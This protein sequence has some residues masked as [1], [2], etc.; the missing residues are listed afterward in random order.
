[1]TMAYFGGIEGGATNTVATIIDAAGKVLGKGRRGGCN[2][3]QIG[4]EPAVDEIV[5]AIEDAKAEAGLK[6]GVTLEGLGLCL[7]GC[8]QAMID[9]I[10]KKYPGLANE[11]VVRDDTIG[12]IATAF[13]RG[14]IVLIAGTGSNCVYVGPDGA[15]K[16]CG[17]WGHFMGDEGSAWWIAHRAIKYLIDND[18]NFKKAPFDV[19]T[20]RSLMYEYFEVKDNMGMLGHFYTGFKKSYFAGFCKHLGIAASEENDPLCRQVFVEAGRVLADHVL[21]VMPYIS[22]DFKS[23]DGITILCTGSVWNSWHLLKDGFFTRLREKIDRSNGKRETIKLLKPVATS[24]IGAAL[25]ASKQCGTPVKMDL[26]QH[27]ELFCEEK[28]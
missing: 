19:E 12:S 8:Q 16:R 22:K 14:G 27:T 23:I 15:S 13:D 2:T 7:G 24:A 17:G 1:M 18:D 3:W 26:S 5:K 6:Q 28:I 21:G 10:K 4:I 20:V 25:L 11:I 9:V